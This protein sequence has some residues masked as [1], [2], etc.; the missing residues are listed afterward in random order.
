[1]YQTA[2]VFP[3]SPYWTLFSRHGPSRSLLVR[4]HT[5]SVRRS[6]KAPPC[7]SL[8]AAYENDTMTRQFKRL[9][10]AIARVGSAYGAARP[11]GRKCGSSNIGDN[12]TVS[13]GVDKQ[14]DSSS[15][16]P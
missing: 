6:T 15:H 3:S 10:S 2:V 7:V 14:R 13:A 4:L 5:Y 16:G 11:R 1:M 8:P 12:R 9:C